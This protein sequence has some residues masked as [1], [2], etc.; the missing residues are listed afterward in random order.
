MSLNLRK[1]YMRSF[2]DFLQ[3][4]RQQSEPQRLLLVFA[5]A[6]LPRDANADERAAFGRG[7]GGAL[8]PLVCVDKLPEEIASFA[9]LKLESRQATPQTRCSSTH[10]RPR[11]A[12]T[13]SSLGRSRPTIR[14]RCHRR[15]RRH[16]G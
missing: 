4:A 16:S 15:L 1:P 3:L 7:E 13:C 10:G 14:R 12:S 6:E 8:A 5:Q 11:A 9:E 2:D